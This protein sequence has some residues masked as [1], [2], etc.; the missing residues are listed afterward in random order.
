MELD[1]ESPIALDAASCARSMVLAKV[2]NDADFLNFTM[3]MM[4]ANGPHIFKGED[5][6][7]PKDLDDRIR[8]LG[9]LVAS[10]AFLAGVALVSASTGDDGFKLDDALRVLEELDAMGV[11]F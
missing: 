2:K 3:G 1:P 6:T 9:S 11:T 10:L 8:W 4:F 5:G 7:S